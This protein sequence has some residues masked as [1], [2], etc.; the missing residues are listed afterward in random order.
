[1][2]LI[3]ERITAQISAFIPGMLEEYTLWGNTANAYLIALIAFLLFFALFR[4]FHHAVLWRLEV[5]SGKTS[6]DLDDLFIDLLKSVCGWFYTLASIYLALLFLTISS[7]VQDIATV[8]LIVALV[9]QVVRA[10]GILVEYS[11]SKRMGSNNGQAN[12]MTELLSKVVKTILW[13]LGGLFILSN[14]GVDITALITGLGIGGIAIA[15]ALQNILGDLFSSFSIYF[16]KPFEV[17][18]FISVNGKMGTVLDIGIKST[19]LRSLEGEEIILSNRELSSAQIQN[20]RDMKE[21]RGVL[22]FG[23]TYATAPDDLDTVKELVTTVITEHDGA[24]LDRANAVRFGESAIEFEVAFYS[25]TD[26]FSTHLATQHALITELKRRFEEK[27]IEIAYPTRT[28][29]FVNQQS[30]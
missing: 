25:T 28:V 30:V 10:A 27:G 16:D 7:L 18:D 29:H 21:W 6:T 13:A 15:L 14:F 5:L 9:Y 20:Y 23:V 1:M 22:P 3:S 26:D 8:I 17:G 11:V 19:R 24:R 12:A 2:N 4:M